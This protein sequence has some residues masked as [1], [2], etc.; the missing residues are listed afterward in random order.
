MK[1]LI[2]VIGMVMV[3]EGLPYFA[4][5]EKMQEYMKKMLEM[6]PAQ[7]RIMGTVSVLL[8]LFLCFLALRT[9]IFNG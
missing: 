1:L 8:G 7:L 5:P 6:Q 9:G 2:T 4:F 3:L